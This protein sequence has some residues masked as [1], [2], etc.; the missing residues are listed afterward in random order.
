MIETER[1]VSKD[2]RLQPFILTGYQG[3]P[4]RGAVTIQAFNREQRWRRALAGL[5]KWWGIA[6]LSVL[7]PV[8]HRHLQLLPGAERRRNGRFDLNHAA[9]LGIPAHP[10][11]P[12]ARFEVPESRDLHLRTL[13]QLTGDNALVVE[14]GFDR[15]ACVSLG[16]L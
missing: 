11:G 14:Q 13:L 12:L 6:L 3:A 7:F 15:P 16:H 10:S 1:V 8:V 9:G 2:A 4:T 5:G